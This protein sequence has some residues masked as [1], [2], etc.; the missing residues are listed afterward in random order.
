VDLYFIGEISSGSVTVKRTVAVMG[1]IAASGETGFVIA[2]KA[3]AP[4]PVSL[5]EFW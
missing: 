1:V 4:R 5:P 3:K 2:S